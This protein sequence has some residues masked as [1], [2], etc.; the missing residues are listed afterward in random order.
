MQPRA[1]PAVLLLVCSALAVCHACSPMPGWQPK[2]LA[3]LVPDTPVVLVVNL[4]RV[5]GDIN[6]QEA[7][8][9]VTCVL[10][11]AN[12]TGPTSQLLGRSIRITRYGSS[13]LCRS[14]AVQGASD[15]VLLE[16]S[17]KTT[18]SSSSSNG[19]APG[20]PTY[21]LVYADLHA[22]ARRAT[23][24]NIDAARAALTPQ[25]RAA[26]VCRTLDVAP[27]VLPG[28]PA[29][30]LVGTAQPSEASQLGRVRAAAPAKP[31]AAKPV[32]AKPVATA[33]AAK[34]VP[35]KPEAAK[36]VAAKP[37]VVTPAPAKAVGAGSIP[38]GAV[39][40]TAG[41]LHS[42]APPPPRRR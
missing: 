37:A 30:V 13:S 15:L 29:P 12:L 19:A 20:L 31:V 33:I 16:P 7:T 17:P 32:A 18:P 36:P 38:G 35:A 41:R 23:Q 26:A 21:S 39:P 4:T 8:A 10:K 27:L 34:P 2:T 14:E 5:T 9:T 6:I 3:Q 1:L 40:A 42:E 11:H 28:Q 22:G 24:A 25:Q